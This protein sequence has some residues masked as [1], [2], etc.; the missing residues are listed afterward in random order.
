MSNHRPHAKA[1]EVVGHFEE[2]G[3]EAFEVQ[4][5]VQQKNLLKQRAQTEPR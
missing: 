2:A 4:K 3:Q 1:D 5:L